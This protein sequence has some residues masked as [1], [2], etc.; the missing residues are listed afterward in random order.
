[1][2][3]SDLIKIYS[4]SQDLIPNKLKI[5]LNIIPMTDEGMEEFNSIVDYIHSLNIGQTP[6]SSSGGNAH[7]LRVPL[8]L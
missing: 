5:P 7:L 4:Y 1:M 6:L 2:N 3:I 8:R